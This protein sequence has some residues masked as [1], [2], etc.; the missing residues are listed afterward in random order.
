MR[1]GTWGLLFATV[2]WVALLQAA[3]S[4]RS[5]LITLDICGENVKKNGDVSA[6]GRRER[7]CCKLQVQQRDSLSGNKIPSSGRK[8]RI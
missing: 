5:I 8:G 3:K 6:G 2:L 1:V 7:I 4:S